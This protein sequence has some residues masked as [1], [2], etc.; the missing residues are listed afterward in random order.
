MPNEYQW[1]LTS[2]DVPSSH[3]APSQPQYGGYESKQQSAQMPRNYQPETHAYSGQYSSS[4]PSYGG[5]ASRSSSYTHQPGPDASFGTQQH[6]Q[7]P[8]QQQ[9]Y[10]QYPQPQQQPQQQQ[11]SSRAS[12]YSSGGHGAPNGANANSDLIDQSVSVQDLIRENFPGQGSSSSSSIQLSPAL[13]EHLQQVSPR[14]RESK[15]YFLE[16]QNGSGSS[17]SGMMY[18]SSDLAL[19]NQL[20]VKHHRLACMR[21]LGGSGP[22]QSDKV[23]RGTEWSLLDEER[24]EVVTRVA[25]GGGQTTTIST[26]VQELSLF[27]GK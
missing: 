12:S 4:P 14:S 18:P 6:Q 2:G 25:T 21:I 11:Y 15:L 7:Y 16:P 26:T 20:A 24:I 9:Q 23:L 8:Q 22:E 5:Q 19:V 13:L 27:R 17:L 10:Q 1:A 3:H